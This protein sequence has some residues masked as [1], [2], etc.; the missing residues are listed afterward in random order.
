M[1][2]RHSLPSPSAAEALRG[3]GV[4]LGPS[5]LLD[6]GAASAT[7]AGVAALW[8]SRR[9]GARRVTA[10]A[11]ALAPW[12]WLLARPWLL[13]WGASAAELTRALPGD[14]LVP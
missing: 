12:A 9:G 3:V 2:P 10:A 13:H 4:T 7:A 11:L 1:T 8:R 14:E 6:V 5:L